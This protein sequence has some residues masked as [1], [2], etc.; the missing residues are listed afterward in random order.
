MGCW[1]YVLYVF[2]VGEMVLFVWYWWCV[3]VEVMLYYLSLYVLD[4]YE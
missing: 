3:M 2:M 1:L 4:C